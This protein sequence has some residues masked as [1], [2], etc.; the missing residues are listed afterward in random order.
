MT[1]LQSQ[2]MGLAKKLQLLAMGTG[3]IDTKEASAARTFYEGWH[4][5]NNDCIHAGYEDGGGDLSFVS[6]QLE[7]LL[8]NLPTTQTTVGVTDVFPPSSQHSAFLF[9]CYIEKL[10]RIGTEKTTQ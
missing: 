8:T 10:K 1:T 4:R 2:A 7:R 5:I 9:G 6:G 3:F